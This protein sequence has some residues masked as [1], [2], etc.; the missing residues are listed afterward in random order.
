M[1]IERVT[2]NDKKKRSLTGKNITFARNKDRTCASAGPP[3]GGLL[4]LSELPTPLRH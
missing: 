3:P 1:R 2:I 4:H